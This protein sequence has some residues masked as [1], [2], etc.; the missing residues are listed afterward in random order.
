LTEQYAL[1]EKI[2]MIE[3]NS[4]A[5]LLK[6]FR[7][8]KGKELTQKK[9][10]PLLGVGHRKYVGWENRESLP[11]DRELKEIVALFELNEKDKAALYDAAARVAPKI[12]NLELPRNRFFTGREAQFKQIEQFLKENG[13]QPIAICGLG[14]VGKTQLALEYVYRG[15]REVYRTVLWVNAAKEE[16]LRKE[17]GELADLLELPERSEDNQDKRIQAVKKWLKT[18][19]GWLLILDNVDD[20]EFA[21]SFLPVTPGGHILLTMRSQIVGSIAKRVEIKEMEPEEAQRFLLTR[22]GILRDAT[23]LDTIA[24][25]VRDTATELVTLL[26][27]LPLALDQAGAY[28]EETGVSLANYL[29]L[30]HARRHSLL[31]RR[32]SIYGQHPE[33][34]AATV[35][36]SLKKASEQHPMAADILYFCSFLAP[37]DM[38][39]EI[40][41]RAGGSAFDPM[42]FN[43]AIATLQRYSLIKPNNQEK[44]FSMHRLVQDVLIDAMPPDL[45]KQWKERAE[46]AFY[47]TYPHFVEAKELNVGVHL[48]PHALLSA[49]RMETSVNARGTEERFPTPEIV[50]LLHKAGISLD[51]LNRLLSILPPDQEDEHGNKAGGPG[52]L[53]N[54]D[55]YQGKYKQ[56]EP[57]YKQALSVKGQPFGN[58]HPFT[59]T[60]L[61]RLAKDYQRSGDYE[62]AEA[63]YQQALSIMKQEAWATHPDNQEIRKDYADFLRS[64]GRSADA[65]A[66]ESSRE[67]DPGDAEP[68]ED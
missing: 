58:N 27:G 19:T 13:T 16:T 18:R 53:A 51:E 55:W 62:R 48:L 47:T 5:N 23:K 64:I 61:Y 12:D 24:T 21:Q 35:E 2:P 63:L 60:A 26:G 17:Y 29:Q 3:D 31:D 41:R 9:I 14:G 45:R 68:P 39:E 66:I 54:P 44:T 1:L 37:D 25:G 22:A 50:E 11:D 4:F 49:N 65:T 57:S 38:S 7:M 32:G 33:T 28:I 30:Y 43:E 52:K 15:Y 20:L 56:A 67:R 6:T 59:G 8:T 42:T 40:V 34:V 36:L 10:A 46:Q